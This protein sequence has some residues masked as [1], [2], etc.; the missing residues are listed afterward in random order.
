MLVDNASR[1]T[2]G[3][4]CVDLCVKQGASPAHDLLDYF[5]Y[6]AACNCG[7]LMCSAVERYTPVARR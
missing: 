3:G 7:A 4:E 2:G 5:V 1:L 6:S